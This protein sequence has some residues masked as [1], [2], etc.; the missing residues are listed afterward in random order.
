MALTDTP[1]T[2]GKCIREDSFT[3]PGDLKTISFSHSQNF[4]LLFPESLSAPSPLC[5][6]EESYRIRVDFFSVFLGFGDTQQTERFA[7]GANLIRFTTLFQCVCRVSART[8]RKVEKLNFSPIKQ[9]R[10][11]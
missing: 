2:N 6:F 4:N 1:L 8:P 7:V 3:P 9:L 10:E 11:V 5:F